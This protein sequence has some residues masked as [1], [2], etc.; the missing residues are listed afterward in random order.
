MVNLSDIT[1]QAGHGG[2]FDAVSRQFGLDPAQSAR[3]IEALLPAFTMA[4]QRLAL[5]PAAFAD[6]TR[7]LTS[8]TYGAYFDNPN[9]AHA[10]SNGAAVLQQLFR[11]PEATKQVAAQAAALTGVGVQVMQQIMPTLAA[12]LVGGMF[13]YATVEG[14]AD[15]LRQWGDALKAASERLDPPKPQDPWS[16]WQAAA[17]QM[18]GLQ[19]APPPARPAPPEP[20]SVLDA[21]VAMVGAMAGAASVPPPTRSAIP[22]PR[23]EPAPI[24][25][26]VPRTVDVELA[27]PDNPESAD[28]EPAAAQADQAAGAAEGDANPFEAVSQMFEAGREVHAQHVAAFQSILDNVWGAGRKA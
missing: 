25:E 20:S 26:A 15:L 17:G 7:A 3:V 27:H 13:R 5:N 19:P 4:F 18:M 14:F 22:P 11:S 12:T 21:W 8:G 2:G 28:G 6:F 10:A 16:A 23:P 24:P 1:R 9:Q